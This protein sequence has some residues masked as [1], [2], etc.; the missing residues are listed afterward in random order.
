VEEE[1]LQRLLSL[2]FL[3]ANQFGSA[4]LVWR[5]EASDFNSRVVP[6]TL[7]S[8]VEKESLRFSEGNYY[9][10]SDQAPGSLIDIGDSWNWG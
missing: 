6:F 5:V 3:L 4:I 9:A 7:E 10:M 1:S 8:E 2:A